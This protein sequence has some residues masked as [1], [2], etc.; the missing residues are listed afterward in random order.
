MI[1]CAILEFALCYEEVIRWVGR[2][3][4][5]PSHTYC[6]FTM[7]YAE[8]MLGK[9]LNWT[10]IIAHSRSQFIRE[11]IDIPMNINWNGGLIHHAIIKGLL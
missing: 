9:H 8:V 1:A 11:I 10:T 2:D 7:V 3:Q 6:N 4:T 5:L